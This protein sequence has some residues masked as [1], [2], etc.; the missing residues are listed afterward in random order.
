M[1]NGQQWLSDFV[2]QNGYYPGPGYRKAQPTATFYR[3]PL[4]TKTHVD[5][6]WRGQQ[7]GM[8]A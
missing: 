4:S 5:K 2:Q 3:F 6:V 1:F 8:Y 7:Y